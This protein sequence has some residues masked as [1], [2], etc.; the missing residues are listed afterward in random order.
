M[1]LV[2]DLRK[3][4]VDWLVGW[5]AEQLNWSKN[6]LQRVAADLLKGVKLSVSRWYRYL[7]FCRGRLVFGSNGTKSP[8][9]TRSTE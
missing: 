1:I 3:E 6:F 4:F 5:F 8:P 7:S 9:K 2:F